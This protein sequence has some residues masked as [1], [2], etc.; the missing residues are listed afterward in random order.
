MRI[1]AYHITSTNLL[2][3]CMCAWVG[4]CVSVC[5]VLYLWD[6]EANLLVMVTSLCAILIDCW[7]VQRAMSVNG[8]LAFGFIPW[9]SLV[10]PFWFLCTCVPRH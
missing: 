5:T 10:R 7:K 3:T 1:A 8:Y 6:E 9:F 4:P 2:T